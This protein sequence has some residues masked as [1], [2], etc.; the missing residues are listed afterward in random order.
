M[1]QNHIRGILARNQIKEIRDEE[2]EFLG[3]IRPEKTLQRCQTAR[4]EVGY[5]RFD[6]DKEIA[7]H[8]EDP[9]VLLKST[10]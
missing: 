10:Q 6:R 2:M 8:D 9:L 7:T 1:I 4:Y 3:M 5:G